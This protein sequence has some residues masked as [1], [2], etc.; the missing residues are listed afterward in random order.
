MDWARFSGVPGRSENDSNLQFLILALSELG[1][2]HTGLSLREADTPNRGLL[3][4]E[5]LRGLYL[6]LV[7]SRF[8]SQR[9]KEG[10]HF[11]LLLSK[12][13]MRLSCSG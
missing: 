7:N 12:P 9:N 5:T 10:M 8:L 6:N 1:P 2:I 4:G 13:R 3:R 11:K